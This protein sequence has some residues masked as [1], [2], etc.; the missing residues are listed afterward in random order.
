ML[1]CVSSFGCLPFCLSHCST[2]S[3]I[4]SPL[5]LCNNVCRSGESYWPDEMRDISV[6]IGRLP[7]VR[8]HRI[9]LSY[10]Y[11][12]IPGWFC[13]TT[14]V[15]Q[16]I[17]NDLRTCGVQWILFIAVRRSFRWSHAHTSSSFD[18]FDVGVD[19]G[20]YCTNTSIIGFSITRRKTATFRV[21][22]LCFHLG[23]LLSI[24]YREWSSL[25]CFPNPLT[26]CMGFVLDPPLRLSLVGEIRVRKSPTR[27]YPF[28][29]SWEVEILGH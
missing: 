27:V 28:K 17:V 3:Y 9:T 13:V 1:Y 15:D 18:A 7:F 22:I 21:H 10:I 19:A 20:I 25:C 4:Y 24:I 12:Y 14:F 29:Y 11:I 26:A 23:F 2:T 8:S 5:I 16:V 6:A